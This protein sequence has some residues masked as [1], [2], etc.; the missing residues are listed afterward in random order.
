MKPNFNFKYYKE[1]LLIILII[2]VIF[3]VIGIVVPTITTLMKNI[4]GVELNLGTI[5]ALILTIFG[6]INLILHKTPLLWK[7]FMKVPL[8]RG[9]YKGIIN[10]IFEGKK[11]E[12][13]CELEIVQTASKIKIKTSFW[14]LDE[15]GNKELTEQTSSVSLVEEFIKNSMD[16]FELHFYYR[17]NGNINGEIPIRMGYNVLE[18]NKEEK[19]FEGYYFSKNSKSEGNGGIINVQLKRNL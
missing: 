16:V 8:V 7:L 15:K 11:K 1:D 3:P 13:E 14:S 18:Y 10:Y 9:K 17:N 2:I 6:L 4:V 19:K 5:T 12:K